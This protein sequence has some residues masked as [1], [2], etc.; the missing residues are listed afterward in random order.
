[1]ILALKSFAG[2]SLMAPMILAAVLSK[3]KPGIEIVFATFTAMTVFLCSQFGFAPT[4]IGG[5]K[6][7]LILLL[8]L[9]IVTVTSQWIRGSTPQKGVAI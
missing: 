6:I 9:G 1:M 7:E 8:G 5:W 4:V 2:T 3:T